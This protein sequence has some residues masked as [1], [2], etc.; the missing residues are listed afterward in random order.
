MSAR[1]DLA[2]AFESAP[3]MIYRSAAWYDQLY[4]QAMEWAQQSLQIV[5]AHAD[6]HLEKVLDIGCGTGRALD[7]FQR[8]GAS[9]WG[10]DIL[11]I[12][13][14]ASEARCPAAHVSL[15]D[16]RSLA[17]DE[18]FDAVISLGSVFA[19]ALTDADVQATLGT[20]ARLTRPGG[21]LVIHVLNAAA[22]LAGA[23]K[24]EDLSV[25]ARADD[26]VYLGEATGRI[27][28]RNS[29]LVLTRIWRRDGTPV[30]EEQVEIRLMMPIEF[31]GWLD[32]AGFDVLAIAD[33]AALEETN[34]DGQRLWVVARRR[35]SQR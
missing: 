32:R 12:M 3:G 23:V 9:A 22:V 14:A 33:N 10:V 13:V 20:I 18:I 16:M 25:S 26:G 31:Q 5:T 27:Q 21:L 29:R 17:L 30:S 1:K 2:S 19:H 6:G 15:G 24:P 7:L 35:S 8:N 28:R 11:P 4:P 34:L